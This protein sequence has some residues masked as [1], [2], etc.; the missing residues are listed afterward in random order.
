MGMFEIRP[1]ASLTASD[2]FFLIKYTNRIGFRLH[3]KMLAEQNIRHLK[4]INSLVMDI[5]HN[6]IIPNMYFKHLLNQ[7][8]NKISD[9]RDLEEFMRSVAASSRG[10]EDDCR[11][12]IDTINGLHRDLM[13]THQ[14]LLKHHAHV[15][16]FLESLFRRDHFEKGHLV[17]HSRRCK[18]E[19]E[20]IKP[21]LEHYAKR[22]RDRNIV[23]EAPRD[24]GDEE[25]SIMADLGLLSQVFANLFSNAVKYTAGVVDQLGRP[26]KAMAYGRRVLP[27]HFGPGRSGVKFNVF[28]TG[29]HLDPAEA[30]RL[31]DEGYRA[32]NSANQPGTGHGLSFIR[33]VIE[34]HGG[35]VGY[36][37]VA[38][39][40]NIYFILPLPGAEPQPAA[41]G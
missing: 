38:Q 27:G 33:H 9:M 41:N 7:L 18:V 35:E 11:Q 22:L 21:Q 31:F 30:S 1:L 6:V 8:H 16:L 3:N 17:L 40:N 32:P 36:E 19:S 23:V 24:M 25:L 39:G 29:P 10:A 15:S 34:M 26:R 28:T 12:A 20:L 2:K 13:S 14:Q 37:P 5:E 4:F